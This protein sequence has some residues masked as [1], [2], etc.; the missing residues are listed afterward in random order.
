M[1]DQLVSRGLSMRGELGHSF[2]RPT[3][4]GQ[5]RADMREGEENGVGKAGERREGRGRAGGGFFQ[6]GP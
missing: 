6:R 5:H 2:I 1:N 3:H 4:L